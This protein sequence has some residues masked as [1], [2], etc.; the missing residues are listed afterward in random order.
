MPQEGAVS[1][2]TSGL[3][4]ETHFEV[5][6]D[7]DVGR[8][9]KRRVKMWVNDAVYLPNCRKLAVV[10]TGRDIHFY[11]T[12]SGQYNKEVLLYGEHALT[13]LLHANSW[14]LDG[15]SRMSHVEFK[16]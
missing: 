9:Q 2:W 5:C 11:E 14:A 3:Y 4:L 10:T 6:Q 7:P 1:V 8:N 12:T 13:L 15:G 16:K